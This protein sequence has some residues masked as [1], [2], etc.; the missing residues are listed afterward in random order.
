MRIY[1]RI[2]TVFLTNFSRIWQILLELAIT[3]Q[4]LPQLCRNLPQFA[5]T[6][7]KSIKLVE[8]GRIHLSSVSP[9]HSYC[10]WASPVTPKQA[11]HPF[12]GAF[13]STSRGPMRQI[14]SLII[15]LLLRIKQSIQKIICRKIGYGIVTKISLVIGA[16]DSSKNFYY[17]NYYK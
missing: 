13:C 1:I 10:N 16:S 9:R 3:C 17:Y 11:N 4:N 12:G 7:H 8:F 15:E 5:I 14:Y 2:Y 6:C